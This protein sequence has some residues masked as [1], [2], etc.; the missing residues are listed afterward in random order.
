MQ[1]MT[2]W[3]KTR[4]SLLTVGRKLEDGAM[5][6]IDVQD[7]CPA[8]VLIQAYKQ[9]TSDRY[10][11][12]VTEGEVKRMLT[13]VDNRNPIHTSTLFQSIRNNHWEH[14]RKNSITAV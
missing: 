11:L 5:Y 3:G 7:A 12:S 14:H 13:I 4:A 10:T 9:E 8:G 1:G 2:L 6:I